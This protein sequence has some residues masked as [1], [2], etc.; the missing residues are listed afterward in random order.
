MRRTYSIIYVIN[1]VSQ[2]IFTI[3]LHIGLSLL[4]AWFLVEKCGA[5]N[6]LYVVILL[7]G[8]ITGLISMIKFILSTMYALDKLEQSQKDKRRQNGN[9]EK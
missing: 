8:V 9:K 4:L 5:P 3:L 6:W 2:S 7:I 1:I